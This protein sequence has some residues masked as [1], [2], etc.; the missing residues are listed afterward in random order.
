MTQFREWLLHESAGVGIRYS[1]RDGRGLMNNSSLNYDKLDDD[2]AAEVED[3][4]LGLQQP[5]SSLHNQ[6]VIFVFTANG[7]QQHR[8][9]IELLT[10]ASK[11]GVIREELSLDG[12]NIIWQSSDGQLGLIQTPN[13]NQ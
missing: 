7:E 11:R 2:E 10:K 1:H 3:E 4:Y 5:P 6:A 9:L 8:R 12:Y 13:N